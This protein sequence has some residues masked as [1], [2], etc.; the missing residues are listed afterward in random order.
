MVYLAIRNRRTRRFVAGT[1]FRNRP[2]KQIYTSEWRPPLLLSI[3]PKLY[4]SELK[5]RR[6]RL[7]MFELVRVAVEEI[8]RAA[9]EEIDPSPRERTF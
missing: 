9:C 3:D 7:D 8:G 1:D 6:I 4:S 2:V 5:R